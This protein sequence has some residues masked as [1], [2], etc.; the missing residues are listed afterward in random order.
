M[1]FALVVSAAIALVMSIPY[2][3]LEYR[4]GYLPMRIDYDSLAQARGVRNAIVFVREAW[5]SQLIARMWALGVSRTDTESIYR[6]V[7]ACVNTKR[8]AAGASARSMPA[9]AL[10]RITPKTMGSRARPDASR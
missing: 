3:A 7:D 9:Q 1:G 8:E 10:S 2:R 6:A 5:G 4:T